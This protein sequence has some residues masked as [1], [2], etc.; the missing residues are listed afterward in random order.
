MGSEA[1]IRQLSESPAKGIISTH[2]IELSEL[3]NTLPTL[4]NY[5]F[6]HKIEENEIHFDYKLKSGACPDFNAQKLMELM[7]IRLL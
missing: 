5:S 1:L 2:D 6:H 7:G 4:V 3:E